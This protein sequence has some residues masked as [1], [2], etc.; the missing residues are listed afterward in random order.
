[1]LPAYYLNIPFLSRFWKDEIPGSF[2]T[3]G[4]WMQRDGIEPSRK[5][6]AAHFDRRVEAAKSGVA[7]RLT[8]PSKNWG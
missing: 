7:R 4:E 3:R 8:P 1:M 5:R 2:R 6:S